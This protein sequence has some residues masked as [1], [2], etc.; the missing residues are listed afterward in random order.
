V[1]R[2][3]R[4]EIQGLELSLNASKQ[5][6]LVFGRAAQTPFGTMSNADKRKIG[7][8]IKDRYCES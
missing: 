8:F 4:Y 1:D 7:A 2:K 5:T 6:L 3:R